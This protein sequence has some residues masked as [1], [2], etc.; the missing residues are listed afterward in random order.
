[1]VRHSKQS[2]ELLSTSLKISHKMKSL[3]EQ[4]ARVFWRSLSAMVGKTDRLLHI[5][6]PYGLAKDTA[7]GCSFI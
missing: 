7:I 5:V 2:K 1:M 3:I 6:F 4:S